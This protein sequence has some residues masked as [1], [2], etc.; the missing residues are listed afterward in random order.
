MPRRDRQYPGERDV[1]TVTVVPMLA[2]E[3]I[4]RITTVAITLMSASSRV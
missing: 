2:G 1:S 4:L 3:Y